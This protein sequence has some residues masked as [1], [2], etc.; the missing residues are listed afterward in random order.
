[1]KITAIINRLIQARIE[2]DRA[3]HEDMSYDSYYRQQLRDKIEAIN[4]DLNNEF[5]KIDGGSMITYEWVKGSMVA[6]FLENKRVGKIQM[7]DKG[8]WFYIP[9]GSKT[10]GDLYDSLEECKQSLE[11]I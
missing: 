11:V 7:T 10:V 3:D 9:K 2:L 5:K 6:V 1:M 4:V 8:Q